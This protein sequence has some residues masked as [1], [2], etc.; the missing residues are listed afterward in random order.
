MNRV[1]KLSALLSLSAT[2]LFSPLGSLP[3]AFAHSDEFSSNPVAGSTIEA[4]RIPVTLKFA[5]DLLTGDPSISH[6]VVIS[7]T[8]GALV[9]A[10]CATAQGSELTTTAAIDQPG[11]YTLT[12]RTVSIDGHP[13]SGN[14]N[15]KVVN[16]SDYDASKEVID[17]CVFAN[18]S[19]PT[20]SSPTVT[21]VEPQ[22]EITQEIQGSNSSRITA[23]VVIGLAALAAAMLVIRKVRGRASSH[24]NKNE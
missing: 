16:T 19:L 14:F 11:E 21:S 10:L 3:A 4:G 15:F 2:A 8:D 7:S 18:E 1:L 24:K 9:P 17:A 23:S 12:W 5:E 22:T 6:Q 13:T 20:E